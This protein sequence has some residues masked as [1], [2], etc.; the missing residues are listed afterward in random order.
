MNHSLS[1]EVDQV[2]T[3]VGRY[4]LRFHDERDHI[5]GQVK[6]TRDFYESAM[7]K[8]LLPLLAQGDFVVDVGANVGNHAVFFAGEAKCRVLAIEPVAVTHELLVKN[9]ESNGL[10]ESIYPREFGLGDSSGFARA[11]QI[12]NTNLGA[13][14]LSASDSRDDIVV[15]RMDSLPEILVNNVR[16]IKVDV[17]GMEV[18]VLRGA[19]GV[20]VRD[21]PF[22]VCECQTEADFRVVFEHLSSYGYMPLDCFNATPTYLFVPQEWKAGNSYTRVDY[23]ADAVFRSSVQRQR[24]QHELALLRR[25]VARL[26]IGLSHDA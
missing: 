3:A 26:E 2:K 12:D 18:E 6:S 25:Q 21:L 22:I 14:Q 10:E 4:V 13:T 1:K 9:I 20:I 16:L 15:R 7:L 11:E 17:E 5:Y 23:V 8:A 24:L 19:H